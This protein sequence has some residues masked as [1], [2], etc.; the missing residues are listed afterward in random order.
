MQTIIVSDIFGRT[1]AL[2][3]LASMLSDEVK[4]LDPYNSEY[5]S[6]NSETEA[7]AYFISEVGIDKYSELLIELIQSLKS[8]VTLIGF[9]VGAAA[10]WKISDQESV[11]NISSATCF[12]GSQIRHLK[13]VNPLFPITL[14]FPVTEEHFSVAALISSISNKANVQVLQADFYHGFMNYHSK[15]YDEVGYKKYSKALCNTPFDK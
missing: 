2:E 14:I 9:S 5:K 7:Y 10:I 1:K 12:Y 4:I 11:G 15:N 13:Q 8:E 6:F 3:S